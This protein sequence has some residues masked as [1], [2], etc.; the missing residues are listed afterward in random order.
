MSQ[1]KHLKLTLFLAF[2]LGATCFMPQVTQATDVAGAKARNRIYQQ[3]TRVQRTL[4]R[5]NKISLENGSALKASLSGIQ[6]SVDSL[7]Q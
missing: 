6:S 4:N 5:L 3:L 1:Q 7:S 2:T